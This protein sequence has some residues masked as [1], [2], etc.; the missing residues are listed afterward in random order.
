ME[1]EFLSQDTYRGAESDENSWNL[2]AY[3]AG[4]PISYVDT[5]GHFIETLLCCISL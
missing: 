3:C 2:Y 5:S 4:N 1:G